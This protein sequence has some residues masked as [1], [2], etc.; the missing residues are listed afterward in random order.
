MLMSQEFPLTLEHVTP[1][2]EVLSM[3][4][5]ERHGSGCCSCVYRASP[6]SGRYPWGEWGSR[7]SSSPTGGEG[8]G[9]R[10]R[11]EWVV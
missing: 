11:L 9:A 8:H 4:V 10:F 6:V 5:S 7:R 3:Q 2:L 1:M